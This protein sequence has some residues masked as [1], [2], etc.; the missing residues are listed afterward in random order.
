MKETQTA[1]SFIMNLMLKQLPLLS[2]FQFYQHK[3]IRLGKLDLYWADSSVK[4]LQ[5]AVWLRLLKELSL[6]Q[7][8]SELINITRPNVWNRRQLI[9]L[10]VL[11]SL[12]LPKQSS[13]STSYQI[14]HPNKLF[15]TE[16]KY[17][18][19]VAFCHSFFPNWAH[20]PCI[21]VGSSMLIGCLC[22][23]DCHVLQPRAWINVLVMNQ[24][25]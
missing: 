6:C 21:L 24:F 4:G 13:R 9:N 7:F 18:N 23:V 8:P 17:N 2:G 3:K 14:P 25:W 22:L 19:K 5:T 11:R 1:F 20:L 10:Q 16:L 12:R 15:S